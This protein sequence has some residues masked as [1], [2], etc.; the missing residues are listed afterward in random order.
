MQTFEKIGFSGT[1]FGS[2][3]GLAAAKAVIRKMRAEP[4]IERLWKHGNALH[5]AF[6]DA[7]VEFGVAARLGG[8]APRLTFHFPLDTEQDPIV[9]DQ[10]ARLPWRTLF[11]QELI[12]RG[13][14]ANFGLTMCYA[15][16]EY[17][18]ERACEAIRGAF[19]VLAS[20]DDPR[21]R[22]V[23]DPAGAGVRP[24]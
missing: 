15:H 6:N 11:A 23:G 2:T 14:L 16:S 24:A 19:K 3:L 12:A 20:V 9:R 7:S 21:E 5:S 8:L 10:P 18:I 4:V 13:I 1:F 17:D 22:L